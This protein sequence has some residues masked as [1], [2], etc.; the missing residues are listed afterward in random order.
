M[1]R[2]QMRWAVPQNSSRNLLSL[3][4]VPPR[5]AGETKSPETHRATRTGRRMAVTFTL[6]EL[7]IVIAIIAIL[8]SLLLP[9]LNNAREKAKRSQC[10]SN[11]KQIGYAAG[12]YANDHRDFLFMDANGSDHYGSFSRQMRIYLGEAYDTSGASMGRKTI[13]LCPSQ[14]IPDGVLRIFSGY[15]FTIQSYNAA[16]GDEIHR[17]GCWRYENEQTRVYQSFRFGSRVTN[18]LLMTALKLFCDPKWTSNGTGMVKSYEPGPYPSLY[19]SRAAGSPLFE[20]QLTGNFL[21]SNLSVKTFP[22]IGKK[23]S[24]YWTMD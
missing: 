19:Q 21:M 5:T 16:R 17:S 13:L 23:A 22:F 4:P 9:A 8:A 20:H 12:M 1:F 15:A 14:E 11:L 6:I 18:G 2:R 24:L 7:L 3:A 10:M